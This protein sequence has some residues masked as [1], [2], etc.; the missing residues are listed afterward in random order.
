LS[1]FASYSKVCIAENSRIEEWNPLDQRLQIIFRSDQ[2]IS[3]FE[4][5][6]ADIHYCGRNLLETA[7]EARHVLFWEALFLGKLKVKSC[8][9][10]LDLSHG[11]EGANFWYEDFKIMKILN[12]KN[13]A[14]LT[15][16]RAY[17]LSHR[18]FNPDKVLK[19][20][21]KAP[22][23]LLKD[24]V[25]ELQ[26]KK[27]ALH[28]NLIRPNDFA[29]YNMVKNIWSF[30]QISAPPSRKLYYSLREMGVFSEF[31]DRFCKIKNLPSILSSATLKKLDDSDISHYC[32]A[33]LMKDLP[34][35]TSFSDDRLNKIKL[36]R[37]FQT[38]A[39][40]A[41]EIK[42]ILSK[43]FIFARNGFIGN[44]ELAK[45][46]ASIESYLM[47]LEK[48]L[49]SL[50]DGSPLS[51]LHKELKVLDV[52]YEDQISQELREKDVWI[53]SRK[54]LNPTLQVSSNEIGILGSAQR[55][56]FKKN[57]V[58]KVSEY[59]AFMASNTNRLSDKERVSVFLGL[60]KLKIAE[61]KHLKESKNHIKFLN[62]Y[63]KIMKGKEMMKVWSKP[64]YE[65]SPTKNQ[66]SELRIIYF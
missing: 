32:T 34:K 5:P 44:V 22:Q 54:A 10:F 43:R 14:W 35:L 57:Y 20:K 46:V 13:S 47:N 40:F 41:L 6:L 36:R 33:L 25:H 9:H 29:L 61:I 52:F 39:Y 21:T 42:H 51:K 49:I 63:N 24:Y 16:F 60:C 50:S 19:T 7:H 4:K 3:K 64:L 15:V 66:F 8:D 56:H 28:S 23:K 30:G 17:T 2:G 37:S 59:I 38:R 18:Y 62:E 65:I 11:F 31:Y 45:L 1:T 55:F 27:S 12:S 48:L 26:G 58:R 53:S